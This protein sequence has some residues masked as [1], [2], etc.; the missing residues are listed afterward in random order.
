MNRMVV[1]IN[2]LKPLIDWLETK[3]DG[4]IQILVVSE[5]SEP[6]LQKLLA[7]LVSNRE[8]AKWA[9]DKL[10]NSQLNIQAVDSGHDLPLNTVITMNS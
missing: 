9:R 10:E 3:P 2:D 4:E 6:V 1:D 8:L 7:S 5:S